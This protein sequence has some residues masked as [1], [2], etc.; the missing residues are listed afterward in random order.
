MTNRFDL[1]LVVPVVH[2]AMDLTYNAT[3][4]DFATHTVSPTTHV[5]ATGA[6]TQAFNTQGSASGIGDIVVRGKYA[7]A[8]GP[9]GGLAV[10]VDF[11]LPTG[12]EDEHA[13]CGCDPDQ[14]PADCVPLPSVEGCRRT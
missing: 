8:G 10:G 1:G 2:V 6:K 13:R 9:G 7:L 11:R 4:L 5:F 3:I 12:D 14:V